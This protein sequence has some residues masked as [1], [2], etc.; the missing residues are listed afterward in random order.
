ML[1]R[2]NHVK[3]ENNSLNL[4]KFGKRLE[5]LV[6]LRE[7]VVA[8]SVVKCRMSHERI[9]LAG[10][11]G[12]PVVR[13]SPEVTYQRVG[14]CDPKL[15]AQRLGCSHTMS[16]IK[17]EVAINELGAASGDDRDSYLAGEL[18]WLNNEIHLLDHRK[19]DAEVEL[20]CGL[21]ARGSAAHQEPEDEY[22]RRAKEKIA[23]ME[24][25]HDHYADRLDILKSTIVTELDRLIENFQNVS[26]SD[27]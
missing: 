11:S 20:A 23:E 2:I 15:R 7:E 8:L 18:N 19:S 4:T 13:H 10:D 9:V 5:T 24:L 6:S 14:L 1:P 25:L 17:L 12:L 21:A 16:R 22:V 3:R 26:A 27:Q